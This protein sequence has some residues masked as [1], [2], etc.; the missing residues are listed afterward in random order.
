[1]DLEKVCDTIDGHGVWQMLREL[2]ELA[3]NC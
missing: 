3:E 1:M 2:E